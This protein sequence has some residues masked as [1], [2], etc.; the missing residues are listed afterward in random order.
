MIEPGIYHQAGDRR[1]TTVGE[2][3]LTASWAGISAVVVF[4]VAYALVISEEFHHLRK[5]KPVIL[6]AGLIWAIIG[7][8]YTRTGNQASLE[9]AVREYLVEYAELFLFLLA[10][11]TYVNSMNERRVFKALR[12]WLI[13][14]GFSLRTLFW[15]T[16]VLSFFLSALIDNLTTVLVMSGV[17]L[18][19]G[20]NNK[21]FISVCSVNIVVAANAGGAFSPFGDITT[22]MVWQSGILAF[23]KFF[24]LFIPS[25]VNYVVP[26]LFLSI[27]VKNG[28]AEK[29]AEAVEMRMGAK[30]IMMLFVLTVFM[31]V[32]FHN[33]LHLPPFMGM[34]TGLACLQ[35]FGFYLRRKETEIAANS[36]QHMAGD[37]MPYDTFREIARAEWDTLLFF[38][39]VIMSVGGLTFLG[40]LGGL[41]Q[42]L[43]VELGPTVAN[44]LV[45]VMSAVVDNIPMMVVV[46]HMNPVMG[47]DQ[48]L[49]VTLAAG[50]GGS[51]LS[52]GSAAGVAMMGQAR[53]SYSFFS[54]L[55]WAPVIALGYGS[56]IWVHLLIN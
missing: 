51:L 32:S 14:R 11:M 16:G 5:C 20:G 7:F 33:Y 30:R 27:A 10:A 3:D 37:V 6:A 19:V 4:C 31:A 2:L 29:Q 12:V 42:F 54:H 36:H 40:Y 41:S 28:A 43:Y 21:R 17:V 48:W 56:S 46:L 44:V 34:V 55:K 52:I 35:L 25:V 45:G 26:A 22:L 1:G 15:A 49:L 47:E 24:A 38:F 18:A 8:E 23:H 13:N 39:G 9:P 53:G 50:V